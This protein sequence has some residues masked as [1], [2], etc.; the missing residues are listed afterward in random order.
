MEN[1]VAI[2]V[3]H[4]HAIKKINSEDTSPSYVCAFLQTSD[5]RRMN[6]S[7]NE[8]FVV[9]SGVNILHIFTEPGMESQCGCTSVEHQYGGRKIAKT[10]GVYLIGYLLSG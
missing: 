5:I 7:I 2:L 1:T 8:D 3:L 6:E 9:V 4:C 10:P